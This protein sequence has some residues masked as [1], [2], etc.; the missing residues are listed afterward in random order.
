MSSSNLDN[1]AKIGKLTREPP[2]KDEFLS[3]VASGR[4]RLGDSRNATLKIESRFDL[5]YN[6]SHAL[7]LAALRRQGFRSRDRYLVFQVLPHTLGL[8]DTVWR[9]LGHCHTKRNVI[10]YDGLPFDDARLLD[11]LIAATTKLLEAI[12]AL[13]PE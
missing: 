11:E 5:A 8:A 6:A 10:E 3:L 4:A 1:L 9:V 12:D 7:A 2:A 13:P